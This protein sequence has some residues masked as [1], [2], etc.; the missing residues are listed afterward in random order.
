MALRSYDELRQIFVDEVQNLKP[1]LTDTSEGS[2]LDTLSRA[3]A[4]AISEVT[5]VA[6]SE[7]SKTFFD[8]ANGPTVTGGADD[9]QS[10]AV[11]HFG[12]EFSRP[13]AVKATGTVTFSRPSSAPG[14]VT[15]VQGTSLSTNKDSSGKSILFVT[16]SEVT[17]SGTSVS[18]GVTAVLD[19]VSGNVVAAK[20]VNIDTPLTDPTVTVTNASPAAGGAEAQDDETYRTTIRNKLKSLSGSIATS[21]E[22][23][24]LTASGVA[25]ASAVEI[26]I[27]VIEYDIATGGIKAGKSFF[28]IPYPVVYVADASGNSSPSLVA[29]ALVKV[30]AARAF[31]VYISVQGAIAA[32]LNWT[33][34]IVLN[35]LG[36]NYTALSADTVLIRDAMSQYLLQLDI[37]SGFDVSDATDAIFAQFGTLGTGDLTSAATTTPS[38]DVGGVVGTKI[39]PGTLVA[40]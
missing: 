35:P 14:N 28:R 25:Y 29:A 20:I 1:E 16:D 6:V 15:I 17:L 27:P 31:G 32:S 11:D 22:A 39:I 5:R 9:L 13:G 24:A 10:L 12:S 37:G 34:D 21:I 26:N 30:L 4:L 23:A 40:S 2:T 38:A 18:V 36:P 8:S 33:L 3:A 19:G 7:F